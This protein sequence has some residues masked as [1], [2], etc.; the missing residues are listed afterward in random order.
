MGLQSLSSPFV[1][2]G[3]PEIC[4]RTY[5]RA[6]GELLGTDH[7]RSSCQPFISKPRSPFP[8]ISHGPMKSTRS[9]RRYGRYLQFL[10]TRKFGE[11]LSSCFD[12]QIIQQRH[13][14]GFFD[15]DIGVMFLEH[16]RG[17]LDTSDGQFRN[18]KPINPRHPQRR[19][20]FLRQFSIWLSA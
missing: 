8:P 13:T 7:C 10:V 5:L 9:Q 15:E 2:S 14:L 16:E 19:D 18:I 17:M 12:G 11:L 3:P 20:V 6:T 1:T 4:S